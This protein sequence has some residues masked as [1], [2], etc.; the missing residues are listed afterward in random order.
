[1]EIKQQSLND[2]LNKGG[3]NKNK[4]LNKGVIGTKAGITIYSFNLHQYTMVYFYYL[5]II[6]LFWYKGLFM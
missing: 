6:H 3:T 4:L 5:H 1:M 2:E